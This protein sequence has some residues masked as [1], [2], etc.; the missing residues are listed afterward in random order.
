MKKRSFL[1]KHVL[2]STLTAIAFAFGFTSCADEFEPEQ[3]AGAP[4]TALTRSIDTDSV[5]KYNINSDP[6]VG[7][8]FDRTNW[9]KH[10]SIY[11][12][13]S[14]KGQVD[15]DIKDGNGHKKYRKEMLPW[16]IDKGISCESNLPLNFCNDVTPENGWDLVANFCGDYNNPDTH[17][18]VLYNKYLGKLR[19]FYF[20]P[21]NVRTEANDHNWEIQ[22]NTNV[23]Q[24]SVFGY[25]A[26]I[27]NN[28]SRPD[29][30]KAEQG[31]YWA[32]FVTPYTSTS[33]DLGQQMPKSGWYAFDVDLSVYRGDKQKVTARDLLKTTIYGY[34]S[35]NVDLYGKMTADIKGDMKLEKCCVNTTSGVFG[36]LED[37][38][39]QANAIKSF[40][41]GAKDVYSSL[42]SGDVL[43]A[44]EGGISVA[45]QGC[46]IMGIDYGAETTGFNGYKGDINMKL[47][48][49]IDMSGTINNRCDIV[50]IA[51]T[52]QSVSYYD[53]EK[54]TMGQ[55][56]W[57]LEEA[58][59]VYHTNASVFWTYEDMDNKIYWADKNSPFGGNNFWY[60]NNR[61][62]K[63]YRSQ[64]CYFDPT[65]IKVVLNPNVF[66]PAEIASA[67][68]YATCG[69]RKNAKVGSTEAYRTVQGLGS[70]QYNP[71]GYFEYANRSY[72]E[73]PFDALSSH[74]DKL[75]M[76]TASKFDVQTYNGKKY[77]AFG[78]GDDSYLME[79][80]LLGEENA[81]D[82][83]PAYEVNVT[84]IVMHND[85][86]IVYSRTYL[87]QYKKMHIELMPEVNE[88]YLKN[89]LPKF[90]VPEIYK[91]QMNHIKDIR[92]WTRRTLH[93]MNGT[94]YH[95]TSKYTASHNGH[96]YKIDANE[97]SDSKKET[98]ANLFDNDLSNRWVSHYNQVHYVMKNLIVSDDH[99]YSALSTGSGVWNGS[100]CWFVE[101]KSNFPISPKSYTLIS[102]NDAGKHPEC[103][104][105]VWCLYGKKN[106]KDPWTKL[107]ASSF[108]NQPGDM[109]PNA[110]SK[111]TRELPF[112]LNGNKC[113]DMQYFRF[114]VMYQPGTS[115]P[116]MRLGEIRFNYDD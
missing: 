97:G 48:G 67:K 39:G 18:F 108:N 66:T 114:E 34:K 23:A 77:G 89:N 73:A 11:M 106:P 112:R 46:D 61:R 52:L 76:K 65:S 8:T 55:G 26:P 105:K 102:A 45:K 96:D 29:L 24:H 5:A 38:L 12:A 31:G 86:P 54:T 25:A 41:G 30:I 32:Q 37:I 94:P 21:R 99:W 71:C 15:D 44:I 47:D 57:N 1:V 9:Y 116:L 64:V 60:D 88:T 40:I 20:I 14:D 78:R 62:T 43:G 6:R 74:K 115:S 92:N 95:L 72:D 103:N 100:P 33:N 10:T 107:G 49:T 91:Q 98:F 85:K 2:M 13:Y 22:M 17:Y 82:M 7:T 87:P 80:Q 59:V 70:S 35:S 111:P 58:P 79:P 104:P 51:N 53:I 50:G 42:M 28:M 83:M 109:L 84:L 93:P 56:V 16:A 3:V 4:E 113:E 110:S 90:Y 75:G 19:Y 81:P 68:V 63:P 36:P 69:V 27:K 101:F